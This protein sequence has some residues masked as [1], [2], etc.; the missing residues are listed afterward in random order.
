MSPSIH[1][2][3]SPLRQ[4]MIEDM[5]LRNMSPLTQK[6]YVRAI[7]NFVRFHGNRSPDELDY[8]DVR[9]YQLHLV[10][11]GLQ[12][13]SINPILCGLRFF[14]N[15]TLGKPDASHHIPLMRRSDKLPTV[16]SRQEVV[17][18]LNA[19]QNIKYRTAFTCVYGDN[20]IIRIFCSI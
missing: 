18:F 8:K 12:A 6:A 20:T 15:V 10:S 3:T 16:L 19:A 13:T 17:C 4:R 7:R 2:Q 14:Y 5:Q 9:A 1:K 11:R